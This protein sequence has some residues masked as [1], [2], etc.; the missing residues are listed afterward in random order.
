MI[1]V[2]D[3]WGESWLSHP[4]Q[5]QTQPSQKPEWLKRVEE[6]I[7]PNAPDNRKSLKAQVHQDEK[8]ASCVDC[9]PD[10]TKPKSQIQKGDKYFEQVGEDG[11][12]TIPDWKLHKQH[13]D[14]NQHRVV[15]D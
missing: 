15:V 10:P 12:G 13:F 7:D 9:V 11:N 2:V 8:P 14:Q 5:T 6:K 4:S 1:T 3:P